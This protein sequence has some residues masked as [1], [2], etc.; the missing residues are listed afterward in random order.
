MATI[1]TLLEVPY[2][3]ANSSRNIVLVYKVGHSLTHYL[4]LNGCT[5]AVMKLETNEFERE[6]NPWEKNTP[7]DFARKYTIP[8]Q[9]RALIGLTGAA[10]RV[11]KAILNNT[12]IKDAD[13][14]Q[15]VE[16]EP[17]MAK[18]EVKEE[19]GFRKPEGAVAKI[20]GYLDKKLD[21]IKAGIISRKELID[22]MVAKEFNQSTVVT[23]CGV[24]ARLNG[25]TFARP[26]QAAENKSG[27]RKAAAKK[28][29][30]AKAV[31]A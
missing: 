20:H 1:T 11:L 21:T 25:I 3:C 26:T 19:G 13:Y 16:K 27:A 29:A 22:Q 8:D 15:P 24:W 10:H 12:S 23:Q 6:Y 9:S 18:A 31:P 14:P 30:K 5:L 17:N 4:G 28:T 2:L 7:L